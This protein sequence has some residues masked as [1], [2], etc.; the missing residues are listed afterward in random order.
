VNIKTLGLSLGVISLLGLSGCGGGSSSSTS[1]DVTGQFIDSEVAGLEY[2][3]SSGKEGVT[4]TNGYFTCKQGDDVNFSINGLF[5]G[6]AKAQ[7]IVTPVT[8]APDKVV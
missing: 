2:K 1:T 3:C 8:L 5:L 6:S 4:D 7:D